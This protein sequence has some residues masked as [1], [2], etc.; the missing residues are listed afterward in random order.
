VRTALDSASA[1]VRVI[2]SNETDFFEDFEASYGSLLGSYGAAF[3]NEWDLYTATLGEETAAMRRSLEKLRTAEAAATIAA[4]GDPTVLN[5][6]AVARDSATMGFGL[7]Y[8]HSFGPGPA[9]SEAVRGAWQRRIQGQVAR[10]VDDLHDDML[11]ALGA[12]VPAAA[13]G[14]AHVVFNALSWSRTDAVDL[15]SA[16][17]A[18]RHAVDLATGA[19]VPSQEVTVDGAPRLRILAAGVPSVG[20]R[21]YVVRP[22]APGAFPPSAS[23]AGATV[24]DGRYAVTLGAAGQVTSLVDHG[25]GDRELV[26]AGGSLH[27]LGSGAG[28][29]TVESAGPVSTTLRVDAG[30]TPAHVTRV[31]LVRGVNRV[32]IEGLITQNFGDRQRYRYQFALPGAVIRHEEVGMIA[33]VGRLAQGGDYADEN[34]RTDGLTFNHFVDL[35]QAARGVTLSNWDSQFFRAGNSTITTL[36]AATPTIEAIVGMQVDGEGSGLLDQG[37]DSRF[38]NRYALRTHGAWDAAA[39]M[40]FALEHQDPLVATPATGGPEAGLAADSSSF[41]VISDPNVLLWA[42]KP[43]EEGI[44][45]GLIARVWNL[46]DIARRVRIER[47][48]APMVLARRTTHL[49]TDLGWAPLVAGALEDDVPAHGMRSWRVAFDPQTLDT[50]PPAGGLSLALGPNPLARGGTAA[51]RFTLARAGRV[52]LSVHDVGGREIA[53]LVDGPR[54]AGPWLEHW[55]TRDGRGRNVPAGVYLVRL[56]TPGGQRH[57]RLVVL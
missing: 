33:R 36:D 30:G 25:D 5:G 46:S 20:Y 48:Q 27:A 16:V 44:G 56:V 18:P 10:Y 1:S 51:L 4:L 28:T 40:R 8:D 17:A 24:D 52:R 23:V 13:S 15:A 47:P 34:T 50:V 45:H 35:S 53:R 26:A 37:G 57:A 2:V 7:Y 19:E 14:E 32:A 29:V 54:G 6:R 38:L 12:M 3:G 11:A 22:G 9:V 42:F 49:E 43:A 55:D 39:A 21:V 31:T 41:L